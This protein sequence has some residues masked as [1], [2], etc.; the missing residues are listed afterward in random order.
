MACARSMHTEAGEEHAGKKRTG[1]NGCHGRLC[2]AYTD[3]RDPEAAEAWP[4]QAQHSHADLAADS[5]QRTVN[6][7]VRSF[8]SRPPT[9]FC[10]RCWNS[11]KR[12]CMAFVATVRATCCARDSAISTSMFTTLRRDCSTLARC[13]MRSWARSSRR[14][15]RRYTCGAP[16]GTLDTTDFSQV[17]SER[18]RAPTRTNYR[19]KAFQHR[20]HA[21]TPR[22][23][24]RTQNTKE[25]EEETRRSLGVQTLFRG[26]HAVDS[27]SNGAGLMKIPRCLVGQC[28]GR[29]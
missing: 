6:T 18:L 22:L 25:L 17:S 23:R 4:R 9:T 24:K 2:A 14:W 8:S 3:G 28:A 16:V 10:V 11:A 29:P 26:A 21:R 15:S 12:F 5:S 1:S 20:A 13:C 19:S 27:G 7:R